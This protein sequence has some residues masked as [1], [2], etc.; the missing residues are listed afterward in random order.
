MEKKSKGKIIAIVILVLL[1]LGLGGYIIY[2]KFVKE[3]ETVELK[4]QVKSLN[5]EI[6]KLKTNNNTKDS[7][8]KINSIVGEY[9]GIKEYNDSPSIRV[10]IDFMEDGTYY[11]EIAS[12]MAI[13]KYGTYTVDNNKITL[14]EVFTHDNEVANGKRTNNKY[15][16]EINNDGTIN[17]T[18]DEQ[19]IILTKTTKTNE[20]KNEFMNWLMQDSEEY[21]K[22]FQVE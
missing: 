15:T 20:V 14:N 4:R 8:D 13:I 11:E 6:D 9:S 16:Y 1:V 2:D 18:I 19:K 10:K 12:T 5:K 17:A 3:D 7:N 22:S 21:T